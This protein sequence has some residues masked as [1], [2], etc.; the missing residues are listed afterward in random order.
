MAITLKDVKASRPEVGSSRK[1]TEG[2][3]T[4]SPPTLVRLRSPPERPPRDGSPTIVSAARSRCS[5]LIS[6]V[7]SLARCEEDTDEGR[8][9]AAEKLRISLGVCDSIITSCGTMH[10]GRGK[11]VIV[12]AFIAHEAFEV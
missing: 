9:S 10:A 4:S 7:T 1:T 12:H 5:N 11:R 6:S 2:L 3:V 8:R